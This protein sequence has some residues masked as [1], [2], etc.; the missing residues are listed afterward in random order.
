MFQSAVT[1]GLGLGL[2]WSGI[3][4]A[5]PI[6]AEE[7][8]SKRLIAQGTTAAPLQ[9]GGTIED[10]GMPL[11]LPQPNSNLQQDAQVLDREAQQ[12]QQQAVAEVIRQAQDYALVNNA[13]V[14]SP[15]YIYSTGGEQMGLDE[16]NL[17]GWGGFNLYTL[18]F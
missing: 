10:R 14:D 6:E 7:R 5:R 15:N 8:D 9:Q 4:I 2:L 11:P 12:A 18:G 16:L 1:L 3:A 17:G 13:Y